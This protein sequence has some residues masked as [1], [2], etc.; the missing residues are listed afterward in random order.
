MRHRGVDRVAAGGVQHALRASGR[1]RR[2]ENEQRVLR[3]HLLAGAI[4]RHALRGLVVI[5]VAAGLH[6]HRRA[7]APDHDHRGDAAGLVAGRVDIVL[8]RNLAAAAQAF[9]SGDD[10]GGLAVLDAAGDRIR[11]EAREHHRMHRADAGAGEHRVSR[12][13]DHRQIDR[14][15]VALLDALRLQHIGE[16]ADLGMQLL[17]GDGLGILGVVAF[18]DDRGLVAALREVP[19]DAII[20]EVETA[21]LEPFDRDIVR[22]VGRV[23]DLGIGLDPVDALALFAPE[24]I[25]VGDRGRIHLLVFGV[26]DEGPLLPIGRDL[27]DLVR[28]RILP[29]TPQVQPVFLSACLDLPQVCD[30]LSCS[31]KGLR[32]RTFVRPPGRAGAPHRCRSAPRPRPSCRPASTPPPSPAAPT[33]ATAS[34]AP[35]P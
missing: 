10:H 17:V 6:L 1:P 4:R 27:V 5:D 34:P 33:A 18:P 13:R 8:Q 3:I 28:H 26:I 12:F 24:L 23:L 16:A 9:V 21:I 32:C 2:I 11:R 20:G 31:D 29:P 7:G 30:S 19:V 22:V 35:C 15:P 14:D 25:R